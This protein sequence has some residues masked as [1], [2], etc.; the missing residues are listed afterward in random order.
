MARQGRF[1]VLEIVALIGGSVAMLATLLSLSRAKVWWVRIWDFPRL[2]LAV[3]ALSALVLW[4]ATA[5]WSAWPQLLFTA[6]TAAVVAF[7]SALIWRYTRLAPREV[8]D[9]EGSDLSRRLSLV[10]SNVLQTNR[11]ADRLLR[12]V[13]EADP[14]VIFCI[15]TDAWWKT[16]LDALVTSHPHV[17]S[18]VLSNMYGMLLYSRLP[19]DAASVDFL[20]QSDIPSIQARVRL[21]GGQHVWLNCVHPAPPGPSGS[22][23]SLERDA[24]LLIVGKRVC[25]AAGP[26]VVCGDLNDVAW[27][28]TTRLFQKVSRLVEPRKGRG[29][30]STFH[31]R[32][33]GLRFPLDH[34]FHSDEFRLVALRRLPYVGSDH[35]SVYVALSHEP[36]AAGEQEAPDADAGD[37]QEAHETILRGKSL[38]G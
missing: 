13:R 22:D 2:Q 18:C 38:R 21:R 5:G 3:L 7:H 16:R 24:E 4:M 34:V 23:K 9:S 15:E 25:E 11:E 6:G 19:L 35:F 10:V 29:F 36:R 33:P 1:R 32:Y 26:V 30:Y 14:D 17:V 8:Q 27:S 28:R 20:V 37:Y 12:V 31:A